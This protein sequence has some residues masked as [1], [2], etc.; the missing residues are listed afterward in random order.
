MGSPPNPGA[1]HVVQI[2]LCYFFAGALEVEEGAA[3]VVELAAAFFFT[4]FL[5]FFTTGALFELLSVVGVLGVWAPKDRAAT[6]AVPN[7]K[8]VKRFI[9]FFLLGR[10]SLPSLYETLA[11]INRVLSAR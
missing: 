6:R 11:L 9:S 4:C 8:V 7:I 2:P 5:C 10:F 3:F 1:S